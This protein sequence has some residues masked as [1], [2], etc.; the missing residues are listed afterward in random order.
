MMVQSF[1]PIT[2]GRVSMLP[3]TVE[4]PNISEQPS[5]ETEYKAQF[6]WPRKADGEPTCLARKSISMNVI[7]SSEGDSKLWF[8]LYYISHILRTFILATRV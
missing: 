4:F 1:P 7:K 6:A 8:Y 5:E 3:K 2:S